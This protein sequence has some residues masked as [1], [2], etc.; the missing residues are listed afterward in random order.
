M[1]SSKPRTT[2]LK[3]FKLKQ[4]Q[5]FLGSEGLKSLYLLICNIWSYFSERSKL[6]VTPYSLVDELGRTYLLKRFKWWRVSVPHQKC[7]NDVGNSL[8][9]ETSQISRVS[10]RFAC[11]GKSKFF[12]YSQ[13]IFGKRRRLSLQWH[14]RLKPRPVVNPGQPVRF[15]NWVANMHFNTAV[16]MIS[17]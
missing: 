5:S 16:A 14:H 10:R 13:A 8:E 7:W 2:E 1:R 3:C 4:G 12:K 11:V 17:P 6:Q 15:Q 9:R